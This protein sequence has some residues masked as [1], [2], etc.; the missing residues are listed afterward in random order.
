MKRR[1][2]AVCGMLA[3]GLAS[4]DAKFE[5]LSVRIEQNATDQDF[6]FVVEATGGDTGFAA[7]TVRAPDGRVVARFEAPKSGLGMRTFRLETPEPKS[8]ARLQA[9]YPAGDYTFTATTV[10]QLQLSDT[11][12]LSHQLPAAATFVRPRPHES[13]VAPGGLRIEWRPPAGL[14]SCVLTIENDVTE[15]KVVQATLAGTANTFQVPDKLLEA[16]ATYKI[17]IGSVAQNGNAS[18]VETLFSVA[19]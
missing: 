15:V 7:L 3:C 16:G 12:R 5:Q 9:D 1:V 17:A 6:E 13:G 14:K 8:F 19:K 11:A 10:T 2:M 4:A 18:Y